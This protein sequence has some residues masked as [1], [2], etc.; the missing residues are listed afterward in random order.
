LG[1]AAAYFALRHYV[2]EAIY[3]AHNS[4]PLVRRIILIRHGESEGNVDR[5][6]FARV[7]DHLIPLTDR[8]R[9]QARAAGAKL[10]ALIGDAPVMFFV[11]PYE[12]TRQT[13]RELRR[14]LEGNPV[15]KAREESRLREQGASW[16]R[17]E[18]GRREGR[19][20][21]ARRQR[22]LPAMIFC[23]ILG[24]SDKCGVCFNLHSP[25]SPFPE[26][27][28]FQD[29]GEQHDRERERAAYGR[30]FFRMKQGESGADVYDRVTTFISTLVRALR[31]RNVPPDTN[32]ILVT[33]GLTMR[34][35]LARCVAC[36]E[37][38]GEGQTAASGPSAHKQADS[39]SYGLVP[40][41]WELPYCL[42]ARSFL[43][44]PP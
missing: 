14:E 19:G 6:L 22:L 36:G 30:F 23:S 43:P 33:H 26:F 1:G 5:T 34:L 11:S 17:V 24:I 27:G 44:S 13:Y 8:G 18:A 32:V 3:R 42:L 12:R 29:P 15:L 25:P 20:A 37:A 4:L 9:A 41:V 16:L 38:L 28:M 40:L 10:K 21:L 35:F 7:P 31:Q 2:D 39:F